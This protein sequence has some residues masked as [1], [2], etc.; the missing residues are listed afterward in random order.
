MLSRVDQEIN[1]AAVIEILHDPPAVSG[2]PGSAERIPIQFPPRITDDT[3]SANWEEQ[4]VASFEPIAIWRGALPRK[5]TVELTYVVTGGA[6][7]T[8]SI[9]QI[10]AH[11][12]GYFYRSIE[13]TKAPIVKMTIYNHMS[14]PG[15]T[16]RLLDASISHGETLIQ[17]GAGIYP[18]MTKI[19][20]GAALFTN[21]NKKMDIPNLPDKP[22]V[23]WY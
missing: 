17:D 12:K 15:S 22:Q 6:F 18:M 21:I 7:T 9:S 3:K 2:F 1:D 20:V 16:W 11:F 10:A 5:I 4:S 14:Q 13:Q 23:G 8:L 19:R